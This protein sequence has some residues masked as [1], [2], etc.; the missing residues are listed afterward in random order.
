MT[1]EEKEDLKQIKAEEKEIKKKLRVEE[2]Q[3]L[4]ERKQQYEAGYSARDERSYAKFVERLSL[5]DK[6]KLSQQNLEDLKGKSKKT[7]GHL[8]TS[9]ATAMF[10]SVMLTPSLIFLCLGID[11]L[12]EATLTIFWGLVASVST[13]VTAFVEKK[14]HKLKN[15]ARYYE[16]HQD[17]MEELKQLALKEKTEEVSAEV[18][19]TSELEH[20]EIKVQPKQKKGSR[21]FRKKV[22]QNAEKTLNEETD[23]FSADK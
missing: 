18:E 4:V 14:S 21:L 11:V 3:K 22:K 10:G 7:K 19:A 1:R 16:E 23:E 8:I 20:E 12:L 2:R 17:E 15:M 13:I 6:Q 9:F 5:E